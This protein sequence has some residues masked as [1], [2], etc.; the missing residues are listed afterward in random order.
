MPDPVSLGDS[1]TAETLPAPSL[2]TSVE[3]QTAASS[4]EA[5]RLGKIP[6]LDGVRGIAAVIV[7]VCHF[8]V[9]L[10]IPAFAVV[11]G[12]TVPLDMF[13]VLSGFL[14]TS[15]LLREQSKNGRIGKWAF[16]ERRILRLVPA[17]VVVLAAHSLFAYL[18]G[19][20][21]HEEWTSLTAV[22]FY[23]SNWK[24]A[25]NSNAF[26]GNIANGLQHMWSLSFEEQFYLIWP[27]ITI[28]LLTIR[29][30]L[31]TVI[32][33]M[34]AMMAVVDVHMA[35]MYHG[36][37]SY[38]ADFIRTDT[39]AGSI[40]MGALLAHIWVR[41]REPRRYLSV[42]AWIAAIFLLVCMPFTNNTGPFLYRGGLVAIDVACAII[43]LA[44]VDGQWAGRHFFQLKPLVLLGL[45][46]YGVYLWHLPILFAIRY[47]GPHWNDV[48]K[49][50]VAV[51]ATLALSIGSWFLVERPF[52]RMKSRRVT[53]DRSQ[54]A[55]GS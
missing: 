5:R 39:R 34:L 33:V 13:F 22:G 35:L 28:F 24:L 51:T 15:L 41:G 49:V 37:G 11:P 9:I 16:Y 8:N 20:S 38:Y 10:P 48:V 32:A 52:M 19:I 1:I 53:V 43:I 6:G 31:R 47:Y 44:I 26:G 55:A 18:T 4:I 54:A 12:G 3:A 21:F 40:L 36:I 27:W 25:F 14:I 42:A 29:Q 2:Q 7:V 45:I 46:S 30:Q 23:Y 50:V 17:L